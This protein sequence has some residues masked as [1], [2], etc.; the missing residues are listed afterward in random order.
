MLHSHSQLAVPPESPF[1]VAMAKR[2]KRHSRVL[3]ED[4]ERFVS[5]LFQT[6]FHRWGLTRDQ[7]DIAIHEDRP[8][9]LPDAIRTLYACY[10]ESRGKPLFADKTPRN[11]LAIPLLADFFSGSRFVHIIRD[12][13]DVALSLVEQRFGP[14]SVSDAAMFWKRRVEQG[15]RAGLALD[16]RRYTEVRYEDLVAHPEDTIRSLCA[17]L[18]L[19]YETDML[20]FHEHAAAIVAAS[21]EVGDHSHLLEPVRTGIRDWRVD[22]SA[23]DVETFECI[24]GDLLTELSYP[25]RTRPTLRT[26]ISGSRA[27]A[28]HLVRDLHVR[29][30]KAKDRV[31]RLN[32][33]LHLRRNRRIA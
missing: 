29:A 28:R 25:R 23:K 18:G 13:R 17:F 19:P 16:P 8:R 26:R 12:G 21:S 1:V 11:V 4:H 24:A 27:R 9:S 30:S 33:D 5:E 14:A 15:R 3:A 10:S 32:D 20:S 22:M 31:H 6:P 2:S 7:V